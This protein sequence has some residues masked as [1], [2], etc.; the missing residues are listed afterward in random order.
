[1][2]QQPLLPENDN[3]HAAENQTPSPVTVTK[4]APKIKP[5][6]PNNETKFT[7]SEWLYNGAIVQVKDKTR[8]KG[9]WK[10]A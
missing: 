2:R 5:D 7:V 6:T 3:D 9:A 4:E 10:D 1:M 8:T